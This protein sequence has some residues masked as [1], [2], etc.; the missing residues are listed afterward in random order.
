MRIVALVAV[1]GLIVAQDG[2]SVGALLPGYDSTQRTRA[3]GSVLSALRRSTAGELLAEDPNLCFSLRENEDQ[4][5]LL[6][7]DRRSKFNFN[8]FGLRFGKRYNG[9]IYRRAVK[10]ARTSNFSPLSLFSRELEV[11]T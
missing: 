4:W 8:P 7:N 6:C 9:Y 1:C 3:T 10:R 2:G 5:Q 11:P